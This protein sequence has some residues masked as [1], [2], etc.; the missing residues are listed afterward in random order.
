MDNNLK[1]KQTIKSF[2]SYT[3]KN[4][5]LELETLFTDKVA[6]DLSSYTNKPSAI[7]NTN[8]IVNEWQH[9]LP[10]L[11]T[12]H[13]K[14]NSFITQVNG[15]IAHS[16][17]YGYSNYFLDNSTYNLFGSYDFYLEKI[18]RY[19]KITHLIFNYKHHDIHNLKTSA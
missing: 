19:W 11:N 4:N 7:L 10:A 6:L 14:I 5:W 18:N 3:D 13:S 2:F 17:W 8:E 15:K 12:S 1:I 16:Y 9:F